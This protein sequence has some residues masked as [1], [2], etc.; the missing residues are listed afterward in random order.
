MQ[1]A[2]YRKE[3]ASSS[4]VSSGKASTRKLRKSAFPT[5]LLVFRQLGALCSLSPGT[6][7]LLGCSSS[8]CERSF[9]LWLWQPLSF[10]PFTQESCVACAQSAQ[11][12][13]WALTSR[14][15]GAAGRT[16]ARWPDY[17]SLQ[18]PTR[19]SSSL[20]GLQH[21]SSQLCCV[22]LP[23]PWAV[24]LPLSWSSSPAPSSTDRVHAQPGT[25]KFC[26]ADSQAQG[27]HPPQSLSRSE[28]GAPSRAPRL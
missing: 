1:N 28:G 18:P 24:A 22:A 8:A 11:E 27:S 19:L 25:S 5:C 7:F 9:T 2:R 21:G 17:G 26:T 6:G 3:L 12:S 13:R 20:A 4:S 15:P 16:L 23:G 10:H 14:C